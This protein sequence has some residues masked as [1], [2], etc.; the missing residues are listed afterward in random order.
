V[1]ASRG[2]TITAKQV[3]GNLNFPAAFA[4]APGGDIYYGEKNTGT[5]SVLN[6]RTGRH[7]GFFHVSNVGSAGEQGLLGIA[8]PKGFPTTT[9]YLYT[10]ATRTFNGAL[11]N[12]I[13]RIKDVRGKGANMTVIFTSQTTPG[14]YHDGGHIA[15]GPDGNL[16][17]VV[18]ESHNPANS[19]D[20]R[21]AAGKVLRMTAAGGVPKHPPIPN[22]RIYSYGLRNSFGFS[23]DPSTG[24]MWESEAGPECNDEI[25]RI[26]P[27]RNYGWGPHENCS[28]SSP[29]DTNQDGRNPVLPLLWYT[30][31]I[32]PTGLAFCRH[33]GLGAA[34]N[35]ALFFGAYNTGDIRRVRLTRDRLGVATQAVVYHHGGGILSV[36]ASP[37]GHLYFSDGSGIY[38]LVLS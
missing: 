1:A 10:Y 14:T 11:R 3:A 5:I 8:I 25:N 6:P 31:T 28:G 9:P 27:G 2:R 4:F 37:D 12:Q 19:Q 26:V 18:G 22:T 21:I 17:A 15:F 13:V 36:Q 20:L 38:R 7:H 34:N 33:C 30:P 24:R 32:T 23:F 29:R 16:Y 35:G